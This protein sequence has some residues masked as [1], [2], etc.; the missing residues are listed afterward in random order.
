[1]YL[2]IDDVGD[3]C[4]VIARNS[5]AARVLLKLKCWI[6]VGMENDLGPDSD[7][8]GW[9]ILRWALKE[10]FAPN[11]VHI[12]TSNPGAWRTMCA[13]LKDHGYTSDQQL[14]IWEKNQCPA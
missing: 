3:F 6:E 13:D 14:R 5:K 11:R 8:Q 1:M 4:D 2:L 10:G 9:E 12:V 7:E